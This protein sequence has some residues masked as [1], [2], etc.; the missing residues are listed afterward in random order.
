MADRQKITHVQDGLGNEKKQTQSID[1][2]NM[3]VKPAS[4][5]DNSS[6]AII[7]PL[8]PE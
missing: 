2:F 4:V 5:S 7:V 1:L 3:Y 6:S 8:A